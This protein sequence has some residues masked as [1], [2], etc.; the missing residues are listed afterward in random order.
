MPN[1]ASL[2]PRAARQSSPSQRDRLVAGAVA[3]ADREGLAAVSIRRVAAELAIRPMSIYTYITS[4][5]ELLDLM[6]EAVVSEVLVT[7]PLPK[8]WRVAVETIAVQSHHAFV[9]HPW[10]AAISHDRPDLGAN[11]LQHAEQLLAA[12]APLDLPATEAWE[13]LF[14]INDY[15]LGHALRVAHAPPP[16]AGNYPPFDP[17]QFPRLAA[18]IHSARRR[19][20]DTFVAGLSRILDGIA[21]A[22]PNASTPERRSPRTSEPD[23]T[24]PKRARRVKQSSGTGG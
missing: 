21:N 8:D 5:A 3:L 22:R 12:I 4:K 11:A 16:T 13:V 24:T 6:A 14:I 20:D 10:L 15:T 23:P 1:R 17:Q 7:P 19:S 18:T 2:R 9:A